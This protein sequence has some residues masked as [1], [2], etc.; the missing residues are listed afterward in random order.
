[1]KKIVFTILASIIKNKKAKSFGIN[2]KQKKSLAR[3]WVMNSTECS[4]NTLWGRWLE[5]L[6]PQ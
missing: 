2:C 4:E 6:T 1:M 3:I 5:I